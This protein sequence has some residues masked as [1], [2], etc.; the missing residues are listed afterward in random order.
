MRRLTLADV[1]GECVVC[2]S[3]R[4]VVQVDESVDARGKVG[5][6]GVRE[7]ARRAGRRTSDAEVRARLAWRWSSDGGLI[8]N[9][10][11]LDA[12]A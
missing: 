3:T 11:D 12:P 8:R 6:A 4:L 9:S 1:S 2:N 7:E 5:Q 10:G